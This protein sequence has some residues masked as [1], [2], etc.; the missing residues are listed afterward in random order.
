MCS[1][2]GLTI[3]ACRSPKATQRTSV[4]VG[5]PANRRRSA[6]STAHPCEPLLRGGSM[7]ASVVRR[8]LVVGAIL[9]LPAAGAAQEATLSGTVTDS[10]GAVLPGVTVTA[11]HEA[12]GNTFEGVTDDRG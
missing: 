4:R 9:T 8:L 2:L 6:A 5:D 11:V 10:T 12:S 7:T 3:S 1:T